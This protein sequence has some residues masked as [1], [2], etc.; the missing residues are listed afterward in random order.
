MRPKL[1]SGH[2]SVHSCS[3]DYTAIT[4]HLQD[5]SSCVV[6]NLSSTSAEGL[7]P[8]TS[9][10]CV[11]I[12]TFT[13]GTFLWKYTGRNIAVFTEGA[14]LWKYTGRSLKLI[15]L[16]LCLLRYCVELCF[17]LYPYMAWHFCRGETLPLPCI[18]CVCTPWIT[19]SVTCEA[20]QYSKSLLLYFSN[21]EGHEGI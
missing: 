1:L 6:C 8:T 13:E 12:V 3:P 20:V 17:F 19:R 10:P 2:Y 5:N 14:F 11:F 15:S 7:N 16:I 21:R 9:L 4:A 18:N